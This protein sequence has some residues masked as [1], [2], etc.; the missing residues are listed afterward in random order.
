MDK[1]L[2]TKRLKA[3]AL[4]DPLRVIRPASVRRAWMDETPERFAYRCLPLTIAN[5]FGWEILS[6]V[7]FEATWNGGTRARDLEITMLSGAENAV[8]SHFGVGVLTFHVGYLFR[9]E[10]GISLMAMGPANAPKDGIAALTGV[11]ETAWA[12]YPFTM[13]WRFTRTNHPVRFEEGEPICCIMPVSLGLL[14]NTRPE[15]LNLGAD[16]RTKAKFE[17]WSQSRNSF[18][19]DLR[20]Q[21]SEARDAKWQR[22]YHKGQEPDGSP[23]P[24]AHKT[25]VTVRPFVDHRQSAKAR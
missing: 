7:A 6:P 11:I 18:N 10:S 2:H 3:F 16:P 20:V 19:S 15:I 13:N 12:P 21:G 5:S 4:T 17:E 8:T 14:E 1:T 25:A 22:R 9:T 23:T 24:Y